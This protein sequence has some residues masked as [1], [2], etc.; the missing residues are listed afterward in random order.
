MA[1]PQMLVRVYVEPR[2]VLLPRRVFIAL[3]IHAAV[4]VSLGLLLTNTSTCMDPRIHLNCLVVNG[5]LLEK[6]GAVKQ[7][8]KE[9]QMGRIR[10]HVRCV[11]LQHK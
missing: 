5:P 10:Y 9:L 11:I 6:I 1:P 2:R 8:V 7:M 3:P 4:F